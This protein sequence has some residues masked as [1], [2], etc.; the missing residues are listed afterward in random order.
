MIIVCGVDNTGKTTITKLLAKKFKLSPL[1]R[2]HTLPPTDHDD[3]AQWLINR[4]DMPENT[5]AETIVDRFGVGE[6]VYGPVIRGENKL[7]PYHDALISR[8]DKVRPL[9]IL[10]EVPVE[11]MMKDFHVREQY[12][13]AQYL[14]ELQNK[15]KEATGKNAI[16]RGQE[17][18]AYQECKQ[19]YIADNK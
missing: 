4:L 6:Y 9:F 12:P 15:Y 11:Q 13:D 19:K 8:F 5:M 3:Y 7:L 17:T 2:Y 16:W 18:K 1:R 10:C 14:T